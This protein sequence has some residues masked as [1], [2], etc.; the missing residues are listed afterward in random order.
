MESTRVRILKTVRVLHL[1]VGAFI[2]PAI[3]FFAFTGLLQTFSLHE[4]AKNGNY[5]P[6]RWVVSLAQLHKKQTI[7]VRA[8]KLPASMV[9]KSGDPGVKGGEPGAKKHSP[10]SAPEASPR[11]TF[12]MKIF[13]ALVSVGLF[14]STAT[15]L[16]M[17]YSY[18]RKKMLLSLAVA[19]GI[20]VPVLLCFV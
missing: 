7:Q 1:Y 18:V 2:S 12:P 6:P 3:L 13:F 17:S 19:T 5:R 15:G 10:V 8:S 20:V 9:L 16:Y 4:N 11:N 14:I